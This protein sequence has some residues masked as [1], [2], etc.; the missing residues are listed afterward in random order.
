MIIA[1]HLFI[2][3]DA[4]DDRFRLFPK[5]VQ[6]QRPDHRGGAAVRQPPLPLQVTGFPA[7]HLLDQAIVVG[8]GQDYAQVV[9]SFDDLAFY[10]GE[11][12]HSFAQPASVLA[13]CRGAQPIR[14]LLRSRSSSPRVT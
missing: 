9:Q 2:R 1:Q 11:R 12:S 13:T 7:V 10:D 6:V 4:E 8:S 14:N 3:T 5:P